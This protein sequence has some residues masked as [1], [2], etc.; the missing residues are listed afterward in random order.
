M[1]RNSVAE[2]EEL[3][4]LQK[5]IE[6]KDAFILS[7]RSKKDTIVFRDSVQAELRANEMEMSSAKNS[8][9]HYMDGEGSRKRESEEWKRLYLGF[10]FELDNLQIYIANAVREKEDYPRGEIR[11][12]NTVNTGRR[13]KANLDRKHLEEMWC[14]KL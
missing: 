8:P 4:R 13:M 3:L 9:Q 5:E 7:Q 6:E 11:R 10:K 1:L 14:F 12:S 2:M